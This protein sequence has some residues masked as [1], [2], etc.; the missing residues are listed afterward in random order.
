M[1]KV[2]LCDGRTGEAGVGGRGTHVEKVDLFQ[3]T[4]LM[5]FQLPHLVALVLVYG[6]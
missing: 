5:M 6:R 2:R 3:Q 1:G 4:L